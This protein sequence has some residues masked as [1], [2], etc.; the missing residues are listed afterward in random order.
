MFIRIEAVEAADNGVSARSAAAFGVE[1]LDMDFPHVGHVN[2]IGH[3]V[4]ADDGLFI[5]PPVRVGAFNADFLAF[6]LIDHGVTSFVKCGDC[7][8]LQKMDEWLFFH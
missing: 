2:D 3:A 6:T 5:D 1:L 4:V 7:F 8:R